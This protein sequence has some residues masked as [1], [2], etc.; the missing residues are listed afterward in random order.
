MSLKAESIDN[1][2]LDVMEN[3]CENDVDI[4]KDTCI[5]AGAVSED[6]IK[7]IEEE[8][9]KR[10]EEIE[11]ER[12]KIVEKVIIDTVTEPIEDE[13]DVR[14]EIVEKFSALGVKVLNLRSKV[15]WRGKHVSR[16]A[17][18]SPVNLKII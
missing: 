14:K 4:I 6:E 11:K 10:I 13:A 18:I 9:R 7:R 8:E 1:S 3:N 17:I 16:L 2:C 12:D 5:N 15:N